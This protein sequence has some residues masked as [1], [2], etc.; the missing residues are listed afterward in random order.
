VVIAS[1]LLMFMCI[2]LGHWTGDPKKDTLDPD[3]L[4]LG[5]LHFE[6]QKEICGLFLHSKIC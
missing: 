5:Y 4:A 1:P 2:I 6:E 3:E